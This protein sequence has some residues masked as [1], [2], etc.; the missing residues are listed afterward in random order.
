MG[1]RGNKTTR[2]KRREDNEHPPEGILN[3]TE[4][5]SARC[6]VRPTLAHEG[7]ETRGAIRGHFQPLA[8]VKETDDVIVLDT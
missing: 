3:T 5:G 1:H 2:R 7:V 8:V 6:L 4:G